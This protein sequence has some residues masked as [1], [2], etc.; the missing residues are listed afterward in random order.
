MSYHEE[1]LIRIRSVYESGGFSRLDADLINSKRGY[2]QLGNASAKNTGSMK[3]DLNQVAAAAKNSGN[4]ISRE[5]NAGV[6]GA[7]KGWNKLKTMASSTYNTIT[8]GAS[9]VGTTVSQGISKG[10]DTAS[11]SFNKLKTSAS[12]T[13]GTIS[14]GAKAASSELGG[15]GGVIAGLAGGMGI[16]EV[17]QSM[18]TG[19]TAKQFNSAY[20]ATKMS[21]AA[22][23]EYISQIQK[24]VAEVPGD[25]SYMN[26]LLTGAVAKQTN[27]SSTELKALGIAAA[28]YVTVSRSMGKTLLETQMDLKEYVLTGNTGQLERDSILKMQLDTLRGQTTVSGRILALN[29]ALKAEGYQGLSQLDIASIKAEEIKGKFQL[30]ATTV[31]EKLLP[32]IEDFMDFMLQLD[33]KTQGQSTLWMVIGGSIALLALALAPVVGA[34]MSGYYAMK[35]YRIE[36]EKAALANGLNKGPGTGTGTGKTGGMNVGAVLTGLTLAAAAIYITHATIEWAT[37]K[38]GD[39]NYTPTAGG[40]PLSEDDKNQALNLKQLFMNEWGD[41]KLFQGLMPTFPIGLDVALQNFDIVKMIEDN[42]SSGGL[43]GIISSYIEK[44]LVDAYNSVKS[45]WDGLPAWFGGLGARIGQLWGD[46]V[47]YFNDKTTIGGQVYDALKK[48][49]CIIM[50]CSPGIIPALQMLY[51]YAVF[52]F[53]AI[54]SPVI[55]VKNTIEGF[56]LYIMLRMAL[57]QN[58]IV[59]RWNLVRAIV[60]QWI[61]TGISIFTDPLGWAK[62]RYN[63]AK[64]FISPWISSGVNVATNAIATAWEYWERFKNDVKK[65]VQGVVDIVFGGAGSPNEVDYLY[66]QGEYYEEIYSPI[67][68]TSSVTSVASVSS[69]TSTVISPVFHIGSIS[70][71]EE[72]DYVIQKVTKELSDLNDSKGR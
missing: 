22:A 25:D 9:K 4:A 57:L 23:N 61:Q 8:T 15:L 33:E 2:D 55:M 68:T 45:C 3:G 69:S 14:A 38:L 36:A 62:D 60:G 56:V 47:N 7:T 1:L 17:A 37:E 20:L 19:A 6:T 66:G 51:F 65:G 72:A 41:N 13:F 46:V 39:P 32:Y 5:I 35:N 30:A 29:E 24:I 10:V 43:H 11:S 26:Q 40:K 44:P 70:S 27:L 48:I 52:V 50:G 12:S 31:G 49:Y 64:A 63:D 71:R 18:W 16:M 67:T 54:L 53:N 42:L 28:D 34:T 58:D 21:S 59:T